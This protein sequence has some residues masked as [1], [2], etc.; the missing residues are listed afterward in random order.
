MK[1]AAVS[2]GAL[3]AAFVLPN[4]PVA[5][6]QRPLHDGYHQEYD[7]HPNSWMPGGEE[8]AT[9]FGNTEHDLA[10][11]FEKAAHLVEDLR[12]QAHDQLSADKIINFVE[13]MSGGGGDHD[14]PTRP[15]TSSSA[16]AST[17]PSS[18]SW[19]TSIRTL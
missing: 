8:L 5:E 6:L 14:F 4:H 12:D 2:Y 10:A 17:R 7:A 18:P 9:I 15:S 11:G 16:R 19:S 13:H 1:L 3:A